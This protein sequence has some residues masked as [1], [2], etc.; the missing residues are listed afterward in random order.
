MQRI[1]TF[2]AFESRAEEA[3]NHYASIFKKSKI[4]ATTPYPKGAPGNPTGVMTIEF[5]LEGQ[6]YLAMNGGPH[7]K[8]TDGMSLSVNADTQ[9]EIDDY[10][11]KLL[12]GGGEQLPCGWVKD[13][14]GLCWQVNPAILGKMFGDKDPAKTERVMKAMIQM[15]KLDLAALERAYEG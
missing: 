8:M 10:T 12:E 5:E 14:F 1:T 7:F 9:E 15:K 11:A 2:L 13:R 4:V 3:V 6:R